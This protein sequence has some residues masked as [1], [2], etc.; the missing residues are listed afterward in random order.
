[1]KDFDQHLKK[2]LENPPNVP[3]REEVWEKVQSRLHPKDFSLR[4]F[5]GSN[6]SWLLPVLLFGLLM[7]FALWIYQPADALPE[8][9]EHKA[10]VWQTD[11]LYK[12][13]VIYE[14]DT[15]YRRTV[16]I[17]EQQSVEKLVSVP[18][19]GSALKP[20]SLPFRHVSGLPHRYSPVFG[21]GLFGKGMPALALSSTSSQ[22][23]KEERIGERR[24]ATSSAGAFPRLSA[25]G[26]TA[27]ASISGAVPD[28]SLR[29][30]DLAAVRAAALKS[31]RQARFA[32]LA[33]QASSALLPDAVDLGFTFNSSFFRGG[34]LEEKLGYSNG[35]LLSVSLNPR[36]RLRT[37]IELMSI[38]YN[39]YE[40]EY[41]SRYPAVTPPSPDHQLT[42]IEPYL[43]YYYLPLGLELRLHKG[44]KRFEP[45]FL[46]GKVWQRQSEKNHLEY[47]FFKPQVEHEAT[48]N[49]PVYD[50]A[51]Q[52]AWHSAYWW[53]GLG[54][55]WYF[56]PYRRDIHLRFD[57]GYYHYLANLKTTL[58]PGDALSLRATLGYTLP[59][60]KKY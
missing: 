36:I 33:Y 40:R 32:E 21:A 45:Y 26:W 53:A 18:S 41:F 28:F 35:L 46:A 56:L 29:Q 17:Q 2:L 14:Y 5:W 34:V 10:S 47:Y 51:I 44:E 43:T 25:N 13:V 3:I 55:D 4:S 42:S 60:G 37:G 24:H 6:W 38:N 11:T 8:K 22:V 7:P 59:F 30:I 20:W 52:N 31:S 16:V 15:I 49:F 58:T 54:A 12:K 19:Y 39:E 1:M 23:R 48:L 9:L 50:E 57:L 27:L